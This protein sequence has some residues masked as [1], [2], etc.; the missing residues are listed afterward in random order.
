MIYVMT[1]S[2]IAGHFANPL[3]YANT[4]MTLKRFHIYLSETDSTR[5]MMSCPVISVFAVLSMLP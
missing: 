4:C 3:V 1:F 5:V 2:T